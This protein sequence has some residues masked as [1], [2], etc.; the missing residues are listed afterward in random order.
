MWALC[1]EQSYRRD[2]N[3]LLID[4]RRILARKPSENSFAFI[5]RSSKYAIPGNEI[6]LNSS[7]YKRAMHKYF[8]KFLSNEKQGNQ[9]CEKLSEISVGDVGACLFFQR[10]LG[11]ERNNWGTEALTSVESCKRKSSRTG[12]KHRRLSNVTSRSF[13]FFRLGKV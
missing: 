8:I 3:H 7:P 12:W 11:R 6:Y 4:P 1:L 10:A 5:S 13:E 9:F 2:T